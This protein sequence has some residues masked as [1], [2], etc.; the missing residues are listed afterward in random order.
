MHGLTPFQIKA[1]NQRAWTNHFTFLQILAIISKNAWMQELTPL[2]FHKFWPKI[3]K[4]H[5]LTP[6]QIKAK[7]QRAWTNHFTFFPNFG[8]KLKKCM[9]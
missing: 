8:Q 2:H 4:K 9:N 1:K 5:G 3:E 7:N 6:F